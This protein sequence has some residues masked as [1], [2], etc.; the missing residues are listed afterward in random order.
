[1]NGI[2]LIATDEKIKQSFTATLSPV[3]TVYSAASEQ[4]GIE[5]LQKGQNNIAAVLI[6]HTLAHRSGYAFADQMKA[7]SSFSS[8][9]IIAVSD[10]QPTEADMD[11]IEHGY[12][13]FITTATPRQLVYQRIRSAIHA[14]DSLTL[15]EVEKMLQKLPACI[16]LKDAEGKY[17]FSTQTWHHLNTGGDPNWTIRGKT[18]VDIRKDKENAKKAM[19][20]D[21]RIIE[22]GEGTEYV[23]EENQD[24]IQDYL[25]L[26]K[27]P[28]Y[29]ENGKVNGIIALINNVTDYQRLKLELEKRVKTDADMITAMAA[30][31]R[32]IYY[33]NLDKDECMCV[34]AAKKLYAGKMWEGREFSFQE[35]FTDYAQHCVAEADREA[36][37]Q[38]IDPENIRAGLANEAMISFRYLSNKD[39][40]EEYE[41]LRIAG[42]RMIEDRDDHMVHAIAA[43]FTNVDRETR[44]QMEQNRVLAEA[45]ARAEEAN[46]AKTAFLNSMSHE[47]RTPLNMILGLDKIALSDASI[48]PQTRDELEKID[49]SARHLLSLINDILD[50]SWID[51]GR[52]ELKED[53]FSFR[54][55]LDQISI[56]TKGQCEEKGLKFVCSRLEPMGEYFIG[57][58]LRLKQVIF[59]ILG[60]A[61]KFSDA[62]GTVSFSVEQRADMNERSLLSFTIKDTGIGMDAQF[63][64]KLFEPFARED[65]STTNRYGGCGIG[66]AITKNI[67]DLMCGSIEVESEKGRGT[68]FHVS[69]PLRKAQHME[70]VPCEQE[71]ERIDSLAGRHV[72]IVEDMKMNAEILADLLDMDD[73]TS[74]WAENGQR[75]VEMFAQKEEGHFDAILMDMR[76]PVMDGVTATREIRNLKRADAK[77][78]P[79]IAVT[80][81]AFEEDVNQ[82]LQAGMNAH[83]AKPVDID[84]LE[85]LLIQMLAEQSYNQL[86]M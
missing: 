67:V 59:N 51:S 10:A 48:S 9:P 40:V 54:D 56:I 53:V 43:G 62:P 49:S 34:R 66:M 80:A 86:Q 30:D 65:T 73:I 42:V 17:V 24:G 50:M 21:R 27:R 78:I 3:Y 20:A 63:L 55:F 84:R 77:T 31:Y 71:E 39:G 23:I 83:L 14:K 35:G 7:H 37:L 1:M 11:C 33:A 79:I 2:L 18:D 57:D 61:V 74:E 70:T 5:A 38:F 13:D 22:T 44:E 36:F 85:T 25:Q 46:A 76:M 68:T 75:G 58:E 12:Y 26:I 28:V 60:N 45:L 19:E 69:I 16:F 8:V 72:L 15:S 52:M 32:S 64:S 47:M 81:N 4:E 6:E 29:D 41:M 82:C